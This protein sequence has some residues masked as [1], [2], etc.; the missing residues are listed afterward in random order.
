MSGVPTASG[1]IVDRTAASLFVSGTYGHSHPFEPRSGLPAG[2]FSSVESRTKKQNPRR[3]RGPIVRGP[4]LSTL[5]GCITSS[6]RVPCHFYRERRVYLSER[7][8]LSF[9]VCTRTRARVCVCT[10]TKR[11]STTDRA[12]LPPQPSLR[13]IFIAMSIVHCLR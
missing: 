4:P 7:R 11:A 1:F 8:C 13:I 2:F 3:F 6:S 12:L 10:D 9:C 5:L